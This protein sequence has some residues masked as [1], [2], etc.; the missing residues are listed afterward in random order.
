MAGSST[1]E[2][3][4][5]QRSLFFCHLFLLVFWT[6]LPGAPGW[7]W[8]LFFPRPLCVACFAVKLEPQLLLAFPSSIDRWWRPVPAATITAK[9]LNS[10]AFFFFFPAADVNLE[11]SLSD[12]YCR[13]HFLVGL[14]LRETAVALQ[15][16]YDIRYLAISI[17]KN[18]LIKHAFD[19]RYQHKVR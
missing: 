19:N 18:L 4:V 5:E 1:H 3:Q 15:D 9:C 14:L 17:L 11:Y 13:H 2:L 7:W 12:E 6:C 8:S 10:T 16:N